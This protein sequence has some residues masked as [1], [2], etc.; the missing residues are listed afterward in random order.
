MLFLKSLEGM[1]IIP[2]YGLVI[3]DL[4]FPISLTPPLPLVTTIL[5]VLMC[6]TF[7]AYSEIIRVFPY[8]H[9]KATVLK[10]LL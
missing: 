9:L 8:P 10:N 6:L 5:S 3:F 1:V 7:F 4:L 2:H